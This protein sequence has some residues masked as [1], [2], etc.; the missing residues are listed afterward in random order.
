MRAWLPLLTASADASAP[1]D[2]AAAVQAP[3]PPLVNWSLPEAQRSGCGVDPPIAAGS[4]SRLTVD[5][6]GQR[7]SLHLVLPA[8]YDKGYRS[9]AVLGFHGYGGSGASYANAGWRAAAAAGGFI[10]L[11]PGV[12]DPFRLQHPR[13]DCSRMHHC[14]G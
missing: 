14:W 7:R 8:S 1:V 4:T 5:F 12:T 3:R 2:T 13:C 9:A 6:R 11:G 10:L